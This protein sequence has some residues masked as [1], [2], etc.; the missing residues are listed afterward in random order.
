MRKMKQ[1]DNGN[2]QANREGEK[3]KSLSPQ[4]DIKKKGV[5]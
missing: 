1:S 5:F 2:V 4:A 3:N